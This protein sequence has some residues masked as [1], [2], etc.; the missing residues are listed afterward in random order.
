MERGI[1]IYIYMNY[2]IARDSG[3]ILD[4]ILNDDRTCE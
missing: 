2:L 1:Y 4:I 3:G